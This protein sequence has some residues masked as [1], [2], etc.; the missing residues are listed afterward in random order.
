VSQR[1]RT[2]HNISL[3]AT[4]VLLLLVVAASVAFAITILTIELAGVTILQFTDEARVEDVIIFSSDTI[5]AVIAP[6]DNTVA[7]H[8]YKVRLYLDGEFTAE[9]TI[10]WTE[11]EIDGNVKKVIIF[12]N[13]NLE[14]V[15]FIQVEVIA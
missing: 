8:E 5:I 14:D 10:S 6:T 2:L 9:E 4:T 13:L 7:N 3:P 15:T 1:R 12:D 11:D